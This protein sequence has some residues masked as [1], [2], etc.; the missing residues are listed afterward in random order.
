MSTHTTLAA[1]ADAILQ[2]VLAKHGMRRVA[3]EVTVDWEVVVYANSTTAVRVYRETREPGC[4]VQ[5]FR[6]RLP[7]PPLHWGVDERARDPENGYDILDLKSIKGGRIVDLG[8]HS[9]ERQLQE[10]A[11][12]LETESSAVLQGNFSV[13]ADLAAIVES[14]R[15]QR[16]T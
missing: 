6:L 16:R 8:K 3:Q 15:A 9:L 13:F 11:K 1:S 12:L 5:L 2:P 10:Y 14:R 7:G 4:L